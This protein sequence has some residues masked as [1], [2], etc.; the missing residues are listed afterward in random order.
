MPEYL[1]K[2]LLLVLIGP[3]LWAGSS[4]QNGGAE[5]TLKQNFI[6]QS[7]GDFFLGDPRHI[8]SIQDRVFITDHV[9]LS[10]K[11]FDLQGKFIYKF[12]GRG[13]GPGEVLDYTLIWP[14][15]E[16]IF[17]A[18]NFN[19]KILKFN[20]QGEVLEEL[21]MDFNKIAWPKDVETVDRQTFL[22]IYRLPNDDN[23]FHLWNA[24]MQMKKASFSLP[25]TLPYN[26]NEVEE[27]VFL[28]QPG[29]LLVAGKK[30]L[31]V[32]FLYDGRMYE[33]NIENQK[34]SE[35]FT[36]YNIPQKGYVKLNKGTARRPNRKRDFDMSMSYRSKT[37][38][39]LLN[40]HSDGLFKTA[41]GH[42]LHVISFA[43]GEEKKLGIEIYDS[44][45]NYI[46]YKEIAKKKIEQGQPTL[47]R[48][49]PK[50]VDK[51]NNIYFIDERQAK[52]KKIRVYNLEIKSKED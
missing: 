1:K 49:F 10:V 46:T 45:M 43:D 38:T 3:L 9:D 20:I 30:I 50:A 27:M 41:D 36:G 39:I 21:A 48:L 19:G 28:F 29:R 37:H 25:M 14:S 52:E 44:N 6:I 12:G 18:D 15:G 16:N 23:L 4:A 11:V 7:N 22:F 40:S 17:V 33:V 42:V 2:L 26:L 5:V 47:I 34:I 8:L 35:T 32:P 24:D 13:R 31:Y 51:N